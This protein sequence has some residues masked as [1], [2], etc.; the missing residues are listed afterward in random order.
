M[1]A[2]C[3]C[4]QND[5]QKEYEHLLPQ[6]IRGERRGT[7]ERNGDKV[8]GVAGGGGEGVACEKV[9]GVCTGMRWK[10]ESVSRRKFH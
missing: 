9:A 8:S 3:W 5:E 7:G 4:C 1:E 10:I 6:D 2:T